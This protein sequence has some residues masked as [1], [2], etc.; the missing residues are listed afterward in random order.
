MIMKVVRERLGITGRS[1]VWT[2]VLRGISSLIAGYGVQSFFDLEI[3]SRLFL[4]LSLD[5]WEFGESAGGFFVRALSVV[6]LCISVTHWS[7]KLFR[8]QGYPASV[9]ATISNADAR[10]HGKV[11]S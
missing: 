1:V 11:H 4:Q 2:F 3:G 6:A 8:L 10:T 9:T 7:L 5:W